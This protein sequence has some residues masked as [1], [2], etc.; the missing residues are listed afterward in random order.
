LGGLYNISHQV[1]SPPDEAAAL[2]IL[3]ELESSDAGNGAYPYF[4]LAILHKKEAK[5]EDLLQVAERVARASYFDTML[6]AQLA[7]LE[8]QR[9]QSA[10][11]AYALEWLSGQANRIHY[12][13]SLDAVNYVTDG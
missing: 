4:Q 8:S 9:W 7:E 10:T 12:Y 13:A 3:K 11:H 5:K 2:A 1:S 6:T